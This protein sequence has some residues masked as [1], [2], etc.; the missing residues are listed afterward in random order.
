MNGKSWP[1]RPRALD[2]EIA[3]ALFIEE[4]T[5]KTHVKRILMKVRLRDR[6]QAVTF[7]YESG[8]TRAGSR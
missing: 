3:E 7:A 6:V 4:S 8:L 2:G 5:V 1:G